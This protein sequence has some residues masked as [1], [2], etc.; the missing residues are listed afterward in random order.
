MKNEGLKM[1]SLICVEKEDVVCDED[2][3]VMNK[4]RG[5]QSVSAESKEVRF[6]LSWRDEELCHSLKSLLHTCGL[7]HSDSRR[8][9]RFW[10]ET[11]NVSHCGPAE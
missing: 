11:L 10:T 9:H 8:C 4:A 5:W 6:F 1:G 7:I 2:V 3:N